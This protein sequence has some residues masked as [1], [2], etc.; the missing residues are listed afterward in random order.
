MKAKR[1]PTRWLG[2]IVLCF[3]AAS[4]VLGVVGAS[5]A[6]S[7]SRIAFTSFRDGSADV[8]VM[9]ADGTNQRRLTN[10]PAAFGAAVAATSVKLTFV[11]GGDDLR[12][13]NDN[14]DVFLV[15]RDGSVLRFDNVNRSQN[16]GNNSTKEVTLPVPASLRLED[17][18]ALR[19]EFHG[20]GGVGGDNWDLN[21]I[22]VT[23]IQA[24]T[25]RTLLEAR[26]APLMRFTGDA[27]ALQLL[28][29]GHSKPPVTRP[30]RTD[31]DPARHGFRFANMFTYLFGELVSGLPPGVRDIKL[32]GLCGGMCYTALDYYHNRRPIPQQPYMPAPGHAMWEYIKTRQVTSVTSNMD[33]WV[34]LGVNPG[35][36][37][38][39]EFFNW[40]L[41]VGSGRLGP[42]RRA[43]DAGR[44]VVLGLQAYAQ[45]GVG[46]QVVAIGYDMGR[47]Y[48]DLSS[49]AGEVRIFVYDPNF[50]GRIMTLRPDVGGA[51]YYYQED[52]RCRWR[53]Y[54][55]DPNYRAQPPN[56]V[57][58][59][60]PTNEVWLSFKTGGDDLRGGNDN[61]HAILLRRDG[62]EIRFENVNDRRLW[63]NNSWNEVVRALPADIP[64]G[65]IVGIRLETTFGGGLGGDNWNLDALVV[66]VRIGNSNWQEILSV[67]GTP[68]FRFTGSDRSRVF[69]R[70]AR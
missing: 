54:F 23:G 53:T 28:F 33:R 1:A 14:L 49:Y 67:S 64:A 46:H 58:R 57:E 37:R 62:R 44:P 7:A 61:V 3:F 13:G 56:I 36:A 34:E 40:G 26:G 68:L 48:G 66:R 69:R 17:L 24:G 27:R 8:H 43:I 22:A 47:Y 65:D 51:S 29:S 63:Q 41:Q 19:L 5:P 21:R 2:R 60:L 18:A 55:V 20:S 12:G 59:S 31:F 25:T 35:G 10:H 16:W 70:P 39:R 50:P 45:F 30:V 32:A 9:N 11:T 52:P 15:L 38:N 4:S 6:A 42:L